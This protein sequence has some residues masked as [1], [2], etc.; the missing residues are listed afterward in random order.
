VY[1][2][3]PPG[4]PRLF[5]VERTGRVLIRRGGRIL[6][7]PFLDLRGQVSTGSEQG[8][9]SIAFAP[10]YATSRRFVVNYTNPAGDTRV[11]LYRARAG[12]PDAADQASRR[13][14]LR[15]DQPYSNHNG[16]Q[17]QF[18]PDGLLYV[19]TGDGGSA[20]DP[21]ERAQ[22]PASPL[23][24]MLRLDVEDPSPRVETY[25]IGLRNPWRFSFDRATG[26]LWIGD[27]GQGAR[28]EIDRLEPDAPAGANFGWDVYEGSSPFEP[29]GLALADTVRP[30]AEYSHDEGCS[31]TGGYVYRGE[32]VPALRG[33]Y[34]FADYCS[35]TMWRMPAR[36]GSPR[37]LPFP[38]PPALAS[39]GE[40]ARGELYV[41]S[42]EGGVWRFVPRR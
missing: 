26:A 34:V 7:R 29:D 28:E 22:D 25:A 13:V 15:I 16:G 40:D 31:V 38:G 35:S 41:T 11:V 9:L 37:R 36:G 6:R 42:L 23:G 19:G 14:L 39:F 12:D 2:A 30:V 24:K 17:V 3:S 21:E 20:G 18:G 1:V 10:D 5:I 32:D 33:Q 8:L 27:V 4:D